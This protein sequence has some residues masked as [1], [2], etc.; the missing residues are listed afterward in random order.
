M[1]SHDATHIELARTVDELTQWL[2][3]VEVGLTQVLDKST[4]NAIEEEQEHDDNDPSSLS[5][6]IKPVPPFAA[7]DAAS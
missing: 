6:L 5:R 2:S 4:E 7:L 1:H 3:V